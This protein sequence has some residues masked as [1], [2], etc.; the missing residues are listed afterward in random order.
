MIVTKAAYAR[1]RHRTPA[2]LS[3]W[4]RDAKLVPP[5]LVLKDGRELVDVALA[6]E[7]LAE[8]LDPSQQ[9]AQPHP[10]TTCV[11]MPTEP[12]RLLDAQLAGELRVQIA[13]QTWLPALTAEIALELDVEKSV[14]EAITLKSHAR[15]LGTLYGS[16]SSR[17][18]N[19]VRDD[20]YPDAQLT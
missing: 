5:A 17:E 11:E 12:S 7:Q 3:H 10:M 2:A 20:T 13:V 18:A 19:G 16:H 4:I 15:F 1:M 8:I 6:D 9:L 14:V